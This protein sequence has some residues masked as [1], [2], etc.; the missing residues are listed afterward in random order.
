MTNY[1]TDFNPKEY[2][3]RFYKEPDLEDRFTIKFMVE[4]L[5]T[6]SPGLRILELG[7]GP[8]LFVVAT[9]APYAKEIHFCDYAE[10]NLNEVKLWLNNNTDAFNWHP[11][12][13]MVLE[14]EGIVVTSQAIAERATMMRN[15]VTRLIVCDALAKKPLGECVEQPYDLVVAQASTDAA[16]RTVSQWQTVIHNIANTLIKPG[17]WLLI[18]VITGTKGYIVGDTCFEVPPLTDTDIYDGF[19]KAGFAPDTFQLETMNTSGNREYFGISTAVAQ[20]TIVG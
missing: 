14:E 19:V 7:G 20:K 13:G 2:L 15:K 5:Q 10:T 8:T 4:T 12:I 11:Y 16:T 18:S 1:K 6:I 17:G 9:V 3:G